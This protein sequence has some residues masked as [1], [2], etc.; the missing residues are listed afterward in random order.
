MRGPRCHSLARDTQWEWKGTQ[1]EAL[2]SSYRRKKK[3]ADGS[4]VS[5]APAPPPP[6]RSSCGFVDVLSHA[7]GS[8]VCCD[9]VYSVATWVLLSRSSCCH[10]PPC[11]PHFP[12]SLSCFP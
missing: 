3:R 12:F 1:G 2:T 10:A 6:G 4:S 8:C 7:T 9:R 11:P 5:S